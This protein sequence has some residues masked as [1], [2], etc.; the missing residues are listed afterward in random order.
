MLVTTLVSMTRCLAYKSNSLCEEPLDTNIKQLSSHQDTGMLLGHSLKTRQWT[1]IPVYTHMNTI[2][3][4]LTMQLFLASV[5][6]QM[7]G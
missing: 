1:H 5:Q 2:Y 3:C 4:Y 7:A 6:L